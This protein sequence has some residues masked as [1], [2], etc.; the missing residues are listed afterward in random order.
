MVVLL[1]SAA[2]VVHDTCVAGC[3]YVHVCGV[4]VCVPVFVCV[5]MCLC[6]C[7]CVCVF[8]YSCVCIYM[9]IYIHVKDPISICR[10]R[11]GMKT[12]KHCTQER[13]N[14]KNKKQNKRLGSAVLWLLAFPNPN[15]PCIALGQESDQI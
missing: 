11:V 15:V 8:R 14:N 12:R 6:S 13:N 4:S 10:K 2:N 9:Y 7:V 3:V 1:M 5:G